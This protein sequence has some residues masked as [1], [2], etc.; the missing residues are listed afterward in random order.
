VCIKWQ[1][2]CLAKTRPPVQTPGPGTKERE[3]EGGGKKE[4][5]KEGKE[6]VVYIHKGV[7]FSNK[8]EWNYVVCR[9]MDETGDYNV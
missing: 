7:L 6:N 4:R 3:N 1:S 8:K 5:R 2:A 9:K